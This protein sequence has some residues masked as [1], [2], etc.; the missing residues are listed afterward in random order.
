[1]FRKI[2][3]A[4]RG[5]IACRILRTLQT[6]GVGSVA[7]YS[8]ADRFSPHVLLADEAVRLGPAPA[9]QSYLAIDAIVAAARQAGAEAVHP[10]YGFLSENPEFADA[11]EAAGLTFIGPTGG[12]MRAFALKHAARAA[13]A[14]LGVPLLP[15]TGLLLSLADAR[16]AAETIG[17]PVMLKTTAGGGGIGIRLCRRA[18][19]LE[20]AWDA[21][22]QQG[23]SAFGDGGVFI[24]RFIESARHLEVQI[25]GD[26]L[27]EVIA[28]GVRD[29]SVQRRNQKVVEETPAPGISEDTRARLCALAI[30]IGKSVRYRSAGTVEFVYD[31]AAQEFY[32]LEVNTRLQVEHGVTEEV[33]GVDLVAWMVLLAA[34]DLPPVSELE[35]QPRGHSF[36]ARVY[37]E[38]AGRNFQPSIGRLTHVRFPSDVRVETWVESGTEIT[39]F[40]DPMLAKIVVH[41]PDRPAAL[42]ALG[43]ALAETRLDGI[44]TNLHYLRQ[45]CAS[46]ELTRGAVTTSFL[47]RFTY[48]RAA[49]E[50]VVGGTQTTIQDFPGRLGFWNVGVPPSG[51]MDSLALRLANTDWW[52]TSEGGGGIGNCRLRPG[53]AFRLRG[54][55]RPL[56]RSHA[57]GT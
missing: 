6:L 38:D 48:H 57:G 29:C 43:A 3:I 35:V 47:S 40:Y 8:D 50:V 52:A 54:C 22:Q 42:A 36:E 34:G 18:E 10:G 37:A 44:E 53:A 19:E 4:N 2:L 31:D 32:F 25:F 20:E 13:A 55:V 11:C 9:A 45:V 30:E 1:M 51:P 24:E 56:R 7:V 49:I 12:Q 46:P 28:L 21:V 15:G 27:G 17:Y 41:G 26:G 23:R 33:W 16:A 39:P 5:A 14:E